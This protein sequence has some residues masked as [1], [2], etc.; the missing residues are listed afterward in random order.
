[1]L[2][3]AT[4]K[5][6]FWLDPAVEIGEVI[7]CSEDLEEDLLDAMDEDLS[8]IAL[9]IR[10]EGD[11]ELFAESQYMIK[12]PLCLVC[13]DAGLL[14]QALRLYQGRALYRGALSKETLAP[15]V[16]KYGLLVQA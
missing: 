1:M 16:R 5:E 2:P 10:E 9:S 3:A 14:E 8:I 7:T 12:K 13:D 4:E 15:L 11:L 6:L